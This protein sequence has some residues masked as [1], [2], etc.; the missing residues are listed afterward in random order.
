MLLRALVF[1]LF[2]ICVNLIA[3]FLA[4]KLHYP[5]LYNVHASFSEYAVPLPFHWALYLEE[6]QA[7]SLAQTLAA[8]ILKDY[9]FDSGYEKK[10]LS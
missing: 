3:G 1:I 9:P 10:V 6:T 7:C 8:E 2:L 4:V 5:S